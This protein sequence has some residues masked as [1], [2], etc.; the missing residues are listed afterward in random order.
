[1]RRELVERRGGQDLSIELE[2]VVEPELVDAALDDL[3]GVEV[4]RIHPFVEKLVRSLVKLLPFVAVG[5]V[6]QRRADHPIG[7]VLAVDGELQLSFELGEL[8]GVRA[9]QFSE[10]ALASE[11]PQLANSRAAVHRQADRLHDL[12]LREVAVP[13][14][15]GSEIEAV[16]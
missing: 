15:D 8:L 10:I 4:D 5:F 13:L 9:R 16:L 3:G 1:M 6:R 12:R 2:V 7:D 14:V 11:A